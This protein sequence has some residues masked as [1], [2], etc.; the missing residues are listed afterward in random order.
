MC[1][2]CGKVFV[3]AIYEDAAP[4]QVY[5]SFA[6]A[7][8]SCGEQAYIQLLWDVEVALQLDKDLYVDLN[9]HTM[10]GT[11]QTGDY[12]IY[13]MD[14][15]TNNYENS[16]GYF[17]CTDAEG[18]LLQ[19]QTHWATTTQMT[20]LIRSYLPVR[21]D[22]G[23][24][25][26]RYYLGL[27]HITLKPATN[28]VGY[29]AY[30]VANS[31]VCDALSDTDTFGYALRLDGGRSITRTMD[32]YTSGRVV[33]LRVDH[34]DVKNY[35]EAGL[36]AKVF[37]TLADGTVLESSE[38]TITLRSLVETINRE[39][40]RFDAEKLQATA[41]MILANPTMQD[42]DVENILQYINN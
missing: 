16:S 42:W 22:R 41:A 19:V 9:G 12:R 4:K 21:T 36:S 17:A 15:K 40:S 13:G 10:T 7:Y 24:S 8:E 34:Y 14:C 25:F 28:G 32:G 23:W 35:G 18:K 20:G 39:Y 30:F 29:K 27:T 33:T 3:A 31:T 1:G 26:N 11:L 2:S 37:M 5:E 38:H 6:Q